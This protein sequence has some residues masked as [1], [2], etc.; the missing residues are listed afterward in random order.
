M[1]RPQP[2]ALISSVELVYRIQ[3]R[4]DVFNRRACL[5]VVDP[6]K[7][8]SSARS[9]DFAS[10]Q[11]LFAHF[12]RSA[13]RHYLLRV[14]PSAPK[15]EAVAIVRFQRRG[16]HSGRRTLHR[17]QDVEASL[18]E[19]RKKFRHRSTGM[20][21]GLPRGVRVDPVIHPFVIGEI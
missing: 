10:P 4:H 18:N 12:R 13:E 19:G 5:D 6:V 8:E 20:F 7:H 14:N 1:P 16:I 21:K 2:V 9:K 15:N 3:H 17:I 11:N